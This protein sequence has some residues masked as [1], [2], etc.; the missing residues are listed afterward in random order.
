MFPMG[1]IVNPA[2]PGS[3]LDADKNE[4]LDVESQ[5]VVHSAPA[6]AS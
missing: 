3:L 2:S 5:Q 1:A 4:R 6:E